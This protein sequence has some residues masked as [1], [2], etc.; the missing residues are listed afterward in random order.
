ME[1]PIINNLDWIELN[2]EDCIK[3]NDCEIRK[4]VK[5]NGYKEIGCKNKI[6]EIKNY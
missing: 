6:E 4:N 1:I 2:C 3:Y 5:N